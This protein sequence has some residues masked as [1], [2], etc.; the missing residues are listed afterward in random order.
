MMDKIASIE[1]T[2]IQV[3]LENLIKLEKNN[4]SGQIDLGKQCWLGE[5]WAQS[6]LSHLNTGIVIVKQ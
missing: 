5:V 2:N 4:G 6:A 3:Q 1:N